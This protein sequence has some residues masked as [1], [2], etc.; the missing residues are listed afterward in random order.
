MWTLADHKAKSGHSRGPRAVTLIGLVT[1]NGAS[2]KLSVLYRSVAPLSGH[3]CLAPLS[4]CYT[5]LCGAQCGWLA[6][7]AAAR[8]V[9]VYMG[10]GMGGGGRFCAGGAGD[11]SGVLP[12]LLAWRMAL[13]KSF[14]L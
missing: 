9:G 10:G 2:E 8:L 14:Q 7:A 5:L 1:K 4:G 11:E 13:G 3:L 6:P 12:V